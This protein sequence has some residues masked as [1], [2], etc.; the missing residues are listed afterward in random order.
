MEQFL[1]ND[2]KAIGYY[3][4]NTTSDGLKMPEFVKARVGA[5]VSA[6]NYF[7]ES[8]PAQKSAY[9]KNS[10]GLVGLYS[11]AIGSNGKV[12]K[13]T[14]G[15]AQVLYVQGVTSEKAWKN[16][17]LQQAVRDTRSGGEGGNAWD[18]LVDHCAAL[19]QEH[20]APVMVGAKR[21]NV[22]SVSDYGSKRAKSSDE[23]LEE[24]MDNRYTARGVTQSDAEQQVSYAESV[25][26]IDAMSIGFLGKELL[27]K[28]VDKNSVD[29]L[30]M[31]PHMEYNM[32]SAVLAKGGYETGAT[33]VGHSD[34]LLGDDVVS[35]LHYGNFTFY[36]KAVVTNAKN[37]I[38]ARNI[39]CQGYEGGND[40]TF[41][42]DK[43]DKGSLISVLIPKGQASQ[44]QNPIDITG[45][46][47]NG[48]E[49]NKAEGKAHY[50][51]SIKVADHLGLNDDQKDVGTDT[52]MF[53]NR[54]STKNT[55][56]YQ[57]HQFS[58][59][60]TT[61]VHNSVTVNTGHWGPN[62]YPGCGK[63]RAGE[64]KYLDKQS[65]K[66]AISV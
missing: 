12:V 14:E 44:L 11:S 55:V 2:K 52:D 8:E 38:I 31:R 43:D 13:V 49:T 46:F 1:G 59:D 16:V 10:E 40:C 25:L 65:Y 48:Y 15:D 9:V 64:M 58:Y 5:S 60:V 45:Y 41:I 37:V 51:G 21:R 66:H 4:A 35:K 62:V 3:L 26:R 7:A 19:I 47:N 50:Q 61:K 18:T 34:F 39:Y 63:A 17:D 20:S 42:K 36:S 29:I 57:G 28:P 53:V 56:C 32:S 24:I 54:Y 22:N 23:L 33:F 6:K 27:A 30:L